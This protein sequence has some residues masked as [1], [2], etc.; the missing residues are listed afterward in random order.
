M[1]WFDAISDFIGNVGFPIALIVVLLAG[2][3]KMAPEFTKLIET[4]IIFV[5]SL[6]ETLGGLKDSIVA[7]QETLRRM[8]LNDERR[9]G[10]FEALLDHLKRDPTKTP[11]DHS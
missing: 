1:E 10:I 11:P 5:N 9:E 3:W 2:F 7:I 8:E 4:H 6:K